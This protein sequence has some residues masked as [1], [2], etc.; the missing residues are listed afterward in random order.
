MQFTFD[1]HSVHQSGR[2]CVQN[3]YR[4]KGQTIIDFAFAFRMNV[5][6]RER[7]A[8]MRCNWCKSEIVIVIKRFNNCFLYY[9]FIFANAH[10]RRTRVYNRSYIFLHIPIA[11]RCAIFYL[12][13][14]TAALTHPSREPFSTH[15]ILSRDNF[16]RG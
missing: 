4:F 1:I 7:F 10:R 9:K 11:F 12:F 5:Q 2:F 8:T 3:A 6:N 16:L 15:E 13:F 14:G